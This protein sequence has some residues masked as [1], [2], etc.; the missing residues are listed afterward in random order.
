MSEDDERLIGMTNFEFWS[1]F[2]AVIA[3][4]GGLAAWRWPRK[5]NKLDVS[6]L[7]RLRA[8]GVVLRNENPANEQYSDWHARY[9]SWRAKSNEAAT[10][11]STG[12]AARLEP[13][14]TMVVPLPT[15]KAWLHD[16]HLLLLRCLNEKLAR[17][18]AFIKENE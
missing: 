6:E 5:S 18:E 12:L 7:V 16:E 8:D 4:T 9:E 2:I 10:K 11:V 13:L 1:L 14:N 15:N 3:T 17:I